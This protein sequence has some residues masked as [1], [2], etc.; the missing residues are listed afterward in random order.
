MIGMCASLGGS[1]IDVTGICCINRG[2][3]EGEHDRGI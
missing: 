1:Y 3:S 2:V